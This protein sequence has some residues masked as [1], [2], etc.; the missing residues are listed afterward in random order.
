MTL[1]T[2][3]FAD[4]D[5]MNFVEKDVT[6]DCVK[7][8]D[9]A[10]NIQS[11]TA[12]VNSNAYFHYA[13]GAKVGHHAITVIKHKTG[14]G[15]LLYVGFIIGLLVG[16]IA[17]LIAGLIGG[18]DI[19]Q[20]T[21]GGLGGATAGVLTVAAC[22][23][24]IGDV[25]I[26]AFDINSINVFAMRLL[27]VVLAPGTV[28]AISKVGIH[29]GAAVGGIGGA[30]TGSLIAR[31]SNKSLKSTVK[32]SVFAIALGALV[33]TAIGTAG[34]TILGTTLGAI[35]AG[36]III[37]FDNLEAFFGTVLFTG[38]F[39]KAVEGITGFIN[40]KAIGRDD[41]KAIVVGTF[42]G[43]ILKSLI[44]TNN[45]VILGAV[46]GAIISRTSFKTTDELKIDALK[47]FVLTTSSF[48]GLCI[49]LCCNVIF[50]EGV[51]GAVGGALTAG[52]LGVIIAR[53]NPDNIVFRYRSIFAACAG[54][55][56][57]GW[58]IMLLCRPTLTGMFNLEADILGHV[59]FETV[60]FIVAIVGAAEGGYLFAIIVKFKIIIAGVR[61][62]VA[63]I[64]R[65]ANQ[66]IQ[67]IAAINKL[68]RAYARA[69]DQAIVL[70]TVGAII[71]A[72]FELSIDPV[73][74]R[75]LAG[76]AGGAVFGAIT[77]TAGGA[78]IFIFTAI[79]KRIPLP[80]I[81]VSSTQKSIIAI[82]SAGIG[83]YVG[84][85]IGGVVQDYVTSNKVVVFS[86][87][88]AV[89]LTATFYILAR[90]YRL[91]KV[92]GILL[93]D[94][95]DKFGLAIERNAGQGALK[96]WIHYKFA[97]AP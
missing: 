32:A 6:F 11:Y 48:I 59:R 43:V 15:I 64:A 90:R 97:K 69:T 42:I 24:R 65:V 81:V 12:S 45:G 23:A 63:A 17:G 58:A 95:V 84:Q 62:L 55:L 47:F 38:R 93:I 85:Y 36:A 86:I 25:D 75:R 61:F 35:T 7:Q 76:V 52:H 16:F 14:A 39:G 41:M 10:T 96:N 56:G 30:F 13:T 20:M 9:S 44:G 3:S 92:P 1:Q 72:L 8:L 88:T 18:E 49:V 89:I 73:I 4:K 87:V 82:V 21:I 54:G 71:G 70:G 19:N 28:E 2:I 67:I 77:G 53:G 29:G 31:V 68:G 22:I 78:V 66:I 26:A 46:L 33:G 60:P 74:G 37:A 80:I 34:G 79:V 51:G 40:I 50:D 5:L 57:G 91:I 94:I 83:Q 27:I